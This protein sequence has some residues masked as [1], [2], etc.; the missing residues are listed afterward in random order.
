[1]KPRAA[2]AGLA[3]IA[4]LAAK[5][6]LSADK[7]DQ[8]LLQADEIDYDVDRKIVYAKGHVE[9]DYG[10][11]TLLADQVAY[12]QNTDKMTADGHVSVM[13]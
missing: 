3:V 1:M 10:P 7:G 13:A 9:I 8:V 5:P 11:R 6:A 12:D 2:C 4:L